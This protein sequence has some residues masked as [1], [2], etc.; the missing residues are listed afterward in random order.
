M[1]EELKSLLKDL[2]AKMNQSQA[3][4]DAPGPTPGA[5]ASSVQDYQG[6]AQPPP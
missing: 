6:R 3:S 2:I 4:Q 1:D 5:T